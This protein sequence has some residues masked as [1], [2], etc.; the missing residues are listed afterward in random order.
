MTLFLLVFSS[1]CF[2][3]NTLDLNFLFLPT[4]PFHQICLQQIPQKNSSTEFLNS[5]VCGAP[6]F[7]FELRDLFIAS[8]LIHLVVVSGSHFLIILSLLRLLTKKN[9]IHFCVIL[10]YWLATYAQ[11]PGLLA[12]LLWSLRQKKSAELRPHQIVLLAGFASLMIRPQ[13]I[14]SPSL[15]LSWLCCLSLSLW[16][17]AKVRSQMLLSHLTLYLAVNIFGGW[18][19]WT[20]PSCLLLNMTLGT[21]L[22]VVLFPLGAFVVLTHLG[23]SL[24]ALCTQGLIW[25]LQNFAPPETG[26]RPWIWN[27]WW[28]LWIGL[29]HSFIWVWEAQTRPMRIS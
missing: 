13:W 5:L 11:A 27:E 8:S 28:W 29:A 22:S 12:L 1:L 25:T 18:S 3:S 2:F 10:T 4:S 15:Y 14:H 20:H 23:L 26:I 9:W 21:L 19:Q 6:L 16:E 24:F 17:Q 7:N